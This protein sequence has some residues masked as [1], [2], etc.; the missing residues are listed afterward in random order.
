[1]GLS[2]KIYRN[3]EL[4]A[5]ESFDREIIKIGRLSSA[6]LRLDDEKVSRIHAVVEVSA[7]GEVNIIDM[8]SADGTFVNGERV[9]KHQLQNGDEIVL[10]NTRLVFTNEAA[11]SVPAQAVSNFEDD[12]ITGDLTRPDQEFVSG[13]KGSALKSLIKIREN[14]R[15]KVLQSAK[16][17]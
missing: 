7:N 3:G 11:D 9:N 12:T 2:F 16:D 17:L 6:H 4:V 13:R 10:G 15:D 1:M 5:T 8:G 14:F